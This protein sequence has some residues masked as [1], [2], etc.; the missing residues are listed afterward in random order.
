[1]TGNGSVPRPPRIRLGVLEAAFLIWAAVAVL[2]VLPAAATGFDDDD[3]GVHEPAFDALASEGILEGTECGEGLICPHESF[4]RWIMAVWMVR[5]LDEFPSAA[6]TRFADVDPGAWW[7]PYVERLAELRI[8]LGCSTEPAR[9]CP[10]DPV[11]RGQMATFLARAF[12]LAPAPVAGFTDTAGNTHEAAINDLA[13]AG[14]T[15]GCSTEP[16]RYCPDDP[17]SR[18]QMATLLARALNLVPLPEPIGG[19]GPGAGFTAV[20]TGGGHACGLRAD[21]TIIC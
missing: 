4:R 15:A 12:D 8:T 2:L 17:V 13:A 7:S 6:P 11:S 1:M 3:G 19:A 10:D 5:A 21:G 20:A 16:A 9:Y 18:G 14:I